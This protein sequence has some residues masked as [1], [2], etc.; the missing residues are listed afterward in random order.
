MHEK[1]CNIGP[2]N[3]GDLLHRGRLRI[4]QAIQGLPVSLHE[5]VSSELFVELDIKDVGSGEYSLAS[6][7]LYVGS[8]LVTG[9]THP[10]PEYQDYVK[11]LGG[12]HV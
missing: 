5:V 6:L 3:D 10:S 7:R 2:E 4:N 8:W 12:R 11:L 9:K 1:R